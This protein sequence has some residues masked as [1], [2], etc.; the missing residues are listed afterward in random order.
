[1]S[2]IKRY[3]VF[4]DKLSFGSVG[5]RCVKRFESEYAALVY[6]KQQDQGHYRY[7]FYVEEII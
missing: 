4:T 1:M 2:S 5:K 6:V 3:G 7:D